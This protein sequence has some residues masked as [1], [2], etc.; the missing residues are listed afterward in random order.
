MTFAVALVPLLGF[1]GAAVDYSRT[2][3]ARSAMQ[4]ALDSAALMVSKDLSG[5]SDSVGR[6]CHLQGDRLFQR[7]VHQYE[8]RPG[9]GDSELHDQHRRMAPPLPST[10]SGSSQPIS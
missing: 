8:C 7:A 1:V 2:N 6:R 10:A 3:A 5:Q 9:R 4:V